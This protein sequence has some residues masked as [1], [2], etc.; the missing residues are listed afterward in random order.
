MVKKWVGFSL[1]C[2]SGCVSA[3]L[4]SQGE[5]AVYSFKNN[6][7]D[8]IGNVQTIGLYSDGTKRYFDSASRALPIRRYVPFG[9]PIIGYGGG[10]QMKSDTG[11]KIPEEME[12]SW[13][14]MPSS[15]TNPYMGEQVGPYRIKIRARIPEVAL[16]LARR[17]AYSLVITPSVG[18]EPVLFCWALAETG[19][20]DHRGRSIVI[21]GG[22][23]E[24]ED[25]A[26]RSDIDWRKPGVWFPEKN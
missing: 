22:Q 3:G 24:P 10:H 16:Q 17:D 5:N 23:C 19:K 21:A 7:D 8:E 1:L 2:L 9:Q 6:S 4:F 12:I 25:F 14:K 20:S 13:R 11:H 26:W 15:G 18:K